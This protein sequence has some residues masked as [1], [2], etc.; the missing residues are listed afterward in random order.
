MSKHNHK[1]YR[2]IY[3]QHHGSIP[4]DSDGR[5]YDIHHIDG[6]PTNNDITN[7]VALS[8]HDHYEVH[9]NNGDFG[10]CLIMSERMKISPEERSRLSSESNKLNHQRLGSE[11]PIVKNNNERLLNG[12]HNWLG[13]NNSVHKLIENGTHHWLGGELQREQQNKRVEDGIHQWLGGE[14][15]KEWNDIRMKNGTHIFITDNPSTKMIAD[16]THH[17]ITNN[18]V[19]ARIENGTHNFLGE[20]SIIKEKW[21]CEHCGKVGFGRGMR[22]RWHGDNCKQKQK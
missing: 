13:E 9:Y 15:Q 16:G 8:I 6:D 11:H 21:T 22:S 1:L 20:D 14:L 18:P 5:T 10:A 17:F 4:V 2:K 12:T 19:H 7:L 3:E